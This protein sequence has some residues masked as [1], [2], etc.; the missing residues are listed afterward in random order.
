M[1]DKP[2]D[3]AAEGWSLV[4]DQGFLGYVGP[5]W[6]RRDA[7]GPR[8][9]ILTDARHLNRSKRVQG[10]LLMTL[11]DR[12]LGYAAWEAMEGRPC[13]T[14]Q[15]EAQFVGG[16]PIGAFIEGRSEVVRRTGTLVFMRG[17]L[18][19]EGRVVVSATGVWKRLS[20]KAAAALRAP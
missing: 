14:V 11:A 5:L 17:T 10:G 1:S 8:F 16:A 20:D 19:T 9:A 7:D 12:T 2:F 13:V 6:T 18:S 15:F 4:P 3:P